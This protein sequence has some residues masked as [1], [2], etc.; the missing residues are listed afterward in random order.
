MFLP[1]SSGSYICQLISSATNNNRVASVRDKQ[2][3]RTH[4]LSTISFEAEAEE[5]AD[6]VVVSA[7]IL[8]QY[9]GWPG[10]DWTMSQAGTVSF[11]ATS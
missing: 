6:V 1:R 7:L 9:C 2:T 11:A 8:S 3:K 5:I 10:K 4:T